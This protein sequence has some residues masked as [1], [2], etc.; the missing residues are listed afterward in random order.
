MKTILRETPLKSASVLNLRKLFMPSSNSKYTHTLQFLEIFYKKKHS[1]C[2]LK[3]QKCWFF[4]S[5]GWYTNFKKRH[6]I[7]FLQMSREKLV[8]DESN[9]SNFI[10]NLNTKITKPYAWTSVQ[11][12]RIWPE[13][14]A[15]SNKNS[16]NRRWKKGFWEKTSIRNNHV[17]GLCNWLWGRPGR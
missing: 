1:F 3:S 13:L 16:C 14:V 12:R 9:I 4:K 15:T 11:Y 2:I 7:R 8:A 17:N 5:V 10:K 6:D